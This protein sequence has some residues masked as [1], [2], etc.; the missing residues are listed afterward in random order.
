MGL[1]PM[2]LAIPA[3]IV[4][5]PVISYAIWRKRFRLARK[6]AASGLA[7]IGIYLIFQLDASSIRKLFSL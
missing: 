6:I 2:V 1:L 7:W 4:A 3:A 5:V